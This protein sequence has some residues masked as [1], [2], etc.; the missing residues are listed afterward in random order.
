MMFYLLGML[1]VGENEISLHKWSGGAAHLRTVLV[2][3]AHSER[4]QCMVHVFYQRDKT[5]LCCDESW[6]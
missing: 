4:R 3:E 2:D 1:Q 5:R 6:C